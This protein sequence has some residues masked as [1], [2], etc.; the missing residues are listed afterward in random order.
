MKKFSWPKSDDRK[1]HTE[2]DIPLELIEEIRKD[3]SDDDWN[4]FIKTDNA[5]IKR[6]QV[7]KLDGTLTDMGWGL[8][9]IIK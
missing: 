1:Y 7:F 3:I 9:L 5:V 8:F 4:Y 2:K 6:N